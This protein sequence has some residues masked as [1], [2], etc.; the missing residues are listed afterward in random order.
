MRI[1][2][3]VGQKNAGKTTLVVALAREFTR[4]GRRVM[5]IKHATHPATLD[6]QGTDSYRHFHEGMA[7][8]TM[9]VS[10]SLRVL[11]ERAEDR[12]DPV[13]LARRYMADADLVLF[14]GFRR[15]PVPKVEVHRKSLNLPAIY[16]PD[17]ANA[18]DWIAIITDDTGIPGARCR[19]LRFTDTM[20][21]SLLSGLVWEQAKVLPP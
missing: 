13:E 12:A 14:E 8:R 16:S 6:H 9:I 2:S 18:G 1:L 4:Q 20:W 21:L 11:F 3:I 15:A 17:L 10:P 7:E 5:T 19:V